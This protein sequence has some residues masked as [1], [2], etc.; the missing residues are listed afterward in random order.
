MASHG[1]HPD[2]HTHGLADDCPR[3]EEHAANPFYGLDE[4]NLR[5]LIRRVREYEPA[6][7]DNELLAMRNVRVAL[8]VKRAIDRLED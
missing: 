5:E 7:S 8:G 2:T 3:C 1:P 4:D 6:R